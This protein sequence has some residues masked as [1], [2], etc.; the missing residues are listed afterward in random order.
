MAVGGN[1]DGGDA[2][3][4]AGQ[5]DEL[6]GYALGAAPIAAGLI[7]VDG[8]PHAAFTF[9]VN[10]AAEDVVYA[11]EYSEDLVSWR[12]DALLVAAPHGEQTWRAPGAAAGETFWRVRVSLR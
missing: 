12:G 11:V 9:P 5:P 7:D 3:S 4:F 10:H 6:L 8:A 1:P 2:T